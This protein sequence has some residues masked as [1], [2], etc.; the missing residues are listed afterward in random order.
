MPSPENGV[1]E[2]LFPVLLEVARTSIDHGLRHAA[3]LP[4][5]AREFPEPLRERRA[6]F[7]T[8]HRGG[9]LR[10]CVGALEARQPLVTD[11]AESAYKAAFSDSRFA[12]LMPVERDDLIIHI[13]VLS[14]LEPLRADSEDDLCR[15]LRPAIDGLVLRVAECQ[16]TFLPAVWESLSDP[17]EFVRQLKRKAGLRPDFW[18]AEI[19]LFRYTVQSID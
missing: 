3:P 2:R 9:D 1:P 10:G 13:S 15:Q 4:V 5:D 19:E 11:A 12:P 6:T 14:P 18:S 17:G 7:V 8:L 16:G